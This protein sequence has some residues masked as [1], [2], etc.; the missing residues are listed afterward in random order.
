MSDNKL[1]SDSKLLSTDIFNQ[2]KQMS[3]NGK[4]KQDQVDV[5]Y[6]ILNDGTDIDQIARLLGMQTNV[7]TQ[8]SVSTQPPAKEKTQNSKFKLSQRSLDR[9]IGVHP[10]L[11]KIVKKA[12]E[13]SE[14][15]FMVVE[16]LRTLETQK[17]YVKKGVSKTLDSYHLKQKSGYGHAVDLAPIQDG[18]I[19]WNN[20]AQFNMVAKAMNQAAKEYGVDIVHGGDW[21]TFKD[22]PHYQISR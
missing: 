11:V 18:K 19:D 7:D 15:D 1:L 5:L 8:S 3:K 20:I 6:E 2:L 12:I 13:I 22:Y 14:I 9:L 4:I 17:E 16:G 21:K 10:N